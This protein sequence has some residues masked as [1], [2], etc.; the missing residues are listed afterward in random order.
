MTLRAPD[1]PVSSGASP[2]AEI[3]Y[4][5]CVRLLLTFAVTLS[6]LAGQACGNGVRVFEPPRA[7]EPPEL[8]SRLVVRCDAE[9]ESVAGTS[10]DCGPGQCVQ[11]VKDEPEDAAAVSPREDV[12]CPPMPAGIRGQAGALIAFRDVSGGMP[13]PERPLFTV[14]RE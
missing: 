12:S 13:Q 6:F 4:T 11:T 1:D 5:A 2:C 8:M 7:A 10:A 14:R 9:E 3:W